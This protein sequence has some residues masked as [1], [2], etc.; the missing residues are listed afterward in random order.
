VTS[1]QR[2]GASAPG[3]ADADVIAASVLRLA[4]GRGAP[5]TDDWSRVLHAA[6]LERCAV[7]AWA[8]S[9]SLIREHAPSTVAATWRQRAVSSHLSGRRKLEALALTVTALERAGC[10]PVVLK[11]LPLSQRLYGDALLRETADADLFVPSS[12]RS[13]AARVLA[14]DGWRH[15]EGEAPWEESWT[16]AGDGE[17]L[18]LDLHS[19]LLDHNLAHLGDVDIASESVSLEGNAVR[20]HSGALLPAYLAAHAAKHRLPPLL[21]FVDIATLWSGS[22]DAQRRAAMA[23]AQSVRLDGYLEWGIARADALS[24]A[25]DGDP[26]AL[27][28]F[29][30]ARSGRHDAHPMLRDARLASTALDSL[31]AVSAW[32]WPPPLRR[33]PTAFTRRCLSR[34]MALGASGSPVTERYGG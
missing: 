20:A 21:W 8:R 26:A 1:S 28:L 24:R 13:L 11:G 32:V 15:V 4:M 16:R 27:A 17:T 7:L 3:P 12:R 33:H 9:G 22:S 30:V 2:V 10:E 25:A 5:L 34:L 6:V 29:G 19:A 14:G 18:Y 31:R 23:A